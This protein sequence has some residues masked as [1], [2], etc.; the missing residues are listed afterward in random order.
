MSGAGAI[1]RAGSG[2]Y[3]S[4][5]GPRVQCGAPLLGSA[6]SGCLVDAAQGLT[7]VSLAK[8]L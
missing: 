7:A 2:G 8:A 5:L 4:A 3:R 1:A 6:A